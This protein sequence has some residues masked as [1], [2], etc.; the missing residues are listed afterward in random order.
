MLL[1]R[2]S[3]NLTCLTRKMLVHWFDILVHLEEILWVI[4]AL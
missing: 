4:L 1:Q 3:W 2:F